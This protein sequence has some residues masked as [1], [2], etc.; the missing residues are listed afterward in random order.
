[1]PSWPPQEGLAPRFRDP[2]YALAFA[3]IVTHYVRHDLFLEDGALLRGAGV[4]A[5]VPGVL[6]QARLDLQAPL[7][8]AWALREAW[9]GAQLVVV[10]EVGHGLEP[11][12]ER[13]LVRATDRL[14]AELA[15]TRPR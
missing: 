5:D 2:A 15:G 3:R 13:Q 8:N 7:E 14:A 4:L 11:G 9:P 10:D 1:M 12:V 6:V